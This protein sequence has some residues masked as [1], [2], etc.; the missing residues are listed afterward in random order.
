[1]GFVVRVQALLFIVLS[2]DPDLDELA[3]AGE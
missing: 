1:M 3:T 2:V